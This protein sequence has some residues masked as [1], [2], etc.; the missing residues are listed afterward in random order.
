MGFQ[1]YCNTIFRI[2]ELFSHPIL[3]QQHTTVRNR[4]SGLER[5]DGGFSQVW[6]G[7]SPNPFFALFPS[8][9]SSKRHLFEIKLKKILKKKNGNEFGNRYLIVCCVLALI[10]QASTSTATWSYCCWAQNCGSLPASANIY[11][12]L[13]NAGLHYFS[14]T[15]GLKYNIYGTA[16]SKLY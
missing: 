12:C 4:S 7:L 10:R 6:I 11:Y 1:T 3:W 5:K 15:V 2:T 14:K 8:H 13:Q 9:I 16:C